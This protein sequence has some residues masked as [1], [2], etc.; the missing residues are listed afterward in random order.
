MDEIE[1][2]GMIARLR[3]AVA[4]MTSMRASLESGHPWPLHVVEPDAGPESEWGPPEVLAHVA[5]MLPYWLGEIER[6]LD[7][8]P[9]PVPFGRTATDR[10]RIMTIERDRTLPPR[11]LLDRIAAGAERHA[12]RLATLEPAQV[13]RRG[14]HPT[15]GE[16]S[17]AAILERFVVSHAEGHVDQL[18]EALGRTNDAR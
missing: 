13:T 6:I 12:R 1:V 16:L 7:G 3:A 10:L 17:V 11:E 9:E 8:A 18:R 5:E 14:L 15:L 4:G 2:D